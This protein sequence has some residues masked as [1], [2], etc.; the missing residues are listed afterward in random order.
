[1]A[2]II[3]N[4]WAGLTP[5]VRAQAV[6][7]LFSRTS[8]IARLLDA[9]EAG[10]F[11]PKNLDS[12]RVRALQSHGD[13]DIRERAGTLLAGLALG[14]RQDVVDA[15]QD[16]LAMTG[17]RDRGKALFAENCSK[18]H[19]LQG[20]G[21]EVGPDL[22]TVAQAGPDKILVNVLD[23]NREVNPQYVNY[24][25]ETGDWESHSGIIASETATSITMKRADGETDTILRVDIES[26]K[27]D[28][29][30]I[31]PE[32]WEQT[33]DKQGLADLIAY[34]TALE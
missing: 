6:E 10:S 24:T 16:V 3:L 33:I 19:R 30:S 18:C 31:M 1:M 4:A 12:T 22:S 26:V 14:S 9:V 13:A 11:N 25:I 32:G 21:H 29:L 15:Y 7:A 5:Q 34:L 23:P 8:W 17:D 2:D 20:V 27:S 28:N